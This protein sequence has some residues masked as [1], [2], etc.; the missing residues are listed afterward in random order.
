MNNPHRGRSNRVANYAR[1]AVV[2]R[3]AFTMPAPRPVGSF[4]GSILKVAAPV[5]G[6]L[7]GGPAG[8][9]LGSAI[10]G[11][12]GGSKPPATT[13]QQLVNEPVIPGGQSTGNA[14]PGTAIPIGGMAGGNSSINVT[15]SSN[16]SINIGGSGPVAQPR[17]A[18]D[19]PARYQQ[20]YAAPS[21]PAY[22][23]QAAQRAQYRSQVDERITQY[24]AALDNATRNYQAAYSAGSQSGL[25]A[26]GNYYQQVAA[27]YNQLIAIRNSLS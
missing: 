27:G 18:A 26:W 12:V 10:A 21:A 3:G 13:A 1:L 4:L 25:T 11:S 14:I 20:S 5:V 6:G 23:P 16:V 2:R 17:Q 22:D 7:L 15:G 19:I 8:A 24:S 9:A